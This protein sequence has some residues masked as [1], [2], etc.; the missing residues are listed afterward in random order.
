MGKRK[1]RK[2]AMKALKKSKRLSPKQK[3]RRIKALEDKW[4]GQDRLRAEAIQRKENS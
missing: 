3:L 4:A 1:N 2:K